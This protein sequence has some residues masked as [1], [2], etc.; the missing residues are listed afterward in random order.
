MEKKKTLHLFIQISVLHYQE[1]SWQV[2]HGVLE[3]PCILALTLGNLSAF[4]PTL[5]KAG[6]R[7]REKSNGTM[8]WAWKPLFMILS[9]TNSLCQGPDWN[10]ANGFRK[11]MQYILLISM[12][13]SE[14]LRVN[15]VKKKKDSCLL[16]FIVSTFVYLTYLLITYNVSSSLLVTGLKNRN[17]VTNFLFLWSS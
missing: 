7:L 5:E 14:A 10:L 2:Y 12:F 9:C 1:I 15:K 17:T 4:L 16:I 13:L 8:K 6:G 11:I 3:L